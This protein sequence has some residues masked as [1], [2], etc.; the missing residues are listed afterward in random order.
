MELYTQMLVGPC[1]KAVVYD[2]LDG[3]ML[4]ERQGEED[5]YKW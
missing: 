3:R 4:G 5:R 1:I 2:V